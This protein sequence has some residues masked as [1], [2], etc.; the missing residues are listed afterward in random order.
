MFG[1][2]CVISV[3]SVLPQLYAEAVPVRSANTVV[4][5]AGEVRF[6][7]TICEV[8]YSV[9]V[10]SVMTSCLTQ[11]CMKDLALVFSVLMPVLF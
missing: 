11:N 5:L 4:C 9:L 8:L 1:A 7:H 6:T 2:F 3:L 10:V